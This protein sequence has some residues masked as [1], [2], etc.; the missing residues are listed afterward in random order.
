MRRPEPLERHFLFEREEKEPG[1]APQTDGA[2]G[3]LL[4][5]RINIITNNTFPAMNTRICSE[6]CCWNIFLCF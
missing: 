3:L 6:P 1:L 5:E 2:Q 4:K